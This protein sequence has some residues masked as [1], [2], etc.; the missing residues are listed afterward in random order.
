MRVVFVW[1]WVFVPLCWA[2]ASLPLSILV[3][4]TLRRPC[5]VGYAQTNPLVENES[6]F[7]SDACFCARS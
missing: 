7:R 6:A 2:A 3:P 1:L 5:F 4:T